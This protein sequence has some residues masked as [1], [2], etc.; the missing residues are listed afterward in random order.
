MTKS[1]HQGCI[2][3]IFLLNLYFSDLKELQNEL[4]YASYVYSF[5]AYYC[6]LQLLSEFNFLL[7][8]VYPLVVLSAMAYDF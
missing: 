3:A 2:W 7:T 6:F 5:Y 1:I 4:I 8:E